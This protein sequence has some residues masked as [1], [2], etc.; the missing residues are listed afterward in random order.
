VSLLEDILDSKRKPEPWSIV[1]YVEEPHM[2]DKRH[3]QWMQER[4]PYCQDPIKRRRKGEVMEG[5]QLRLGVAS[6]MCLLEESRARKHQKAG[7]PD[8]QSLAARS[9]P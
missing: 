3:E 4:P 2:R 9:F 7:S 1:G 6:F 5:D 8:I